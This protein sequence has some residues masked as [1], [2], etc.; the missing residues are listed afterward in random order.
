MPNAAARPS[1]W[2]PGALAIVLAVTTA[3]VALLALNRT[4]LY[5]DESQYWFWGQELAFGYYSKPPLIG[6]VIRASV[7]LG[8][9]DA[10]FWVR[11]PAPLFHAVT[12]L[13]LAW[14]AGH[15][16][17]R[18][19]ALWVAALYVTLPMVS[20]GSALISTDTIMFPFFAAALGLWLAGLD[21]VAAGRPAW[22][23]ALAAGCAAGVAFLGKYAAIYGPMGAALAALFVPAARP[24]WRMAGWGALGFLF[25]AAPNIGWNVANGLTTL[26]HTLDNVEWVRAPGDRSGLNLAGLAEF[27]GAQFIVFGPVLFGALLW[28]G[29]RGG[30]GSGERRILLWLSL[31]IVAVVCG[32][33]LLEEAY[34]NWAAAAYL[35]GLLAVVQWL[36]TRSRVWLWGSL[37]LHTAFAAALP[38]ALA[39][40]TEW[41]AGDRLLFARYLGQAEMSR[42]ILALAQEHDGEVVVDGR[43]LLAD[44]FHTGRDSDVTI[45][46]RPPRGRPANHYE[47]TRA[48]PD[49]VMGEVLY[50]GRLD[51]LPERCGAL[52][53]IATLAPDSGAYR[54]R[55]MGAWRLPADCLRPPAP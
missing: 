33:A 6:W 36:L 39:F 26:Q 48:M 45:W 18:R 25:A 34:A 52:A 24:G 31:P 29:A 17:G 46:A 50:V 27:F 23:L 12:A 16:Y 49:S 5:M 30:A 1:E 21:R 41:R 2:L 42:D 10:Q 55:P 43:S 22:A 19:A 54:E 44:L 38:L 51:D 53:P 8:G 40:G 11:L 9:S 3:R 32:Q 15:R 47:Q 13:I 4:D 35:A 28:L 20:V 37:A 14:I 7:E